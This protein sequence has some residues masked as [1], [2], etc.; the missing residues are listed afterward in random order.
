LIFAV[1]PPGA[2]GDPPPPEQL[3][4]L[5]TRPPRQPI[6]IPLAAILAWISR[7]KV[8]LAIALGIVFRLVLYL[9]DRIYWMDESALVRNIEELSP[10]GFFGPLLGQQLAPPYFLLANWVTGRLFGHSHLTMR[11]V[12]FLGGIAS[13]FLFRGVAR[14]CLP[15]RAVFPA[16]LMVVSSSDLIYYSAQVKQYSTDVAAALVCL[17]LGL[18]VGSRPLT[19]RAVIWLSAWG[20]VVVGFSYTSMFALAAVGVVG[21]GRALGSKDGRQAVLWMII[22]L[23]WVVEIGAVLGVGMRQFNGDDAMWRF[24]N[25]AFPPIPPHSIWDATW[26]VRRLAYFFVNPLNFD[27]PFGARLSM[28]PAVGLAL[29]GVVRLWKLDR[30]RCALL[31]L[32]VA[33]ALLAACLRLY[34]FHGRLVLY[35]IPTALIPIAAGLDQVREA[36]GR[37]RWLGILHAALVIMVIVVPTAI[38]CYELVEPNLWLHNQHG[39][40]RPDALDADRFPF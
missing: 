21:L 40:I 31:L 19:A 14:R 18:T 1:P 27:A 15:P 6:E 13:L 30:S 35:L 34:P 2:Q 11:L 32:P 10:R 9:S 26:I 28:L 33:F 25:F 20:L 38:A 7:S 4:D 22:G 39:D 5:Q 8:G 24:W 12:A 3:S 29:I 17:L 36:R 23:A 37:G 16:V